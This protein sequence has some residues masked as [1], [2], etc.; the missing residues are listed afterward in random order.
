MQIINF[1]S[2]ENNCP[3]LKGKNSRTEYNFIINCSKELNQELISR[4]WR[5]FGS[6]FSRP[7]CKDCDDCVS[8]R[9][10]V[11]DFVF[12][13]QFKR[14]IKK[15]LNT[16]VVISKPKISD[17][18]IYIYNKYH[19]YMRKKRAW[20]ENKINFS[21]YYRLYVDGNGDFGYEL[22][23]Y[24]EQKL[25]CVDLID[26]LEDGISSIYC[27]YDPDYS[28]L[29]LGKFSLL[30]E[31]NIALKNELSYIYLGYFV[32]GCK[33]LA[34]KAD[35]SPNEILKGTTSLND[36]AKLWEFNN[37]NCSKLRIN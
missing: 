17:E 29:N 19:E 32:E 23:F 9:I 25:V 6:Y 24:V 8:Y 31:I 5:R 16:K 13:K 18:H 12:S 26:I 7:I 2:L 28:H 15:N 4:G 20:E 27:Y 36:S 37:A 3:Y 11:K 21:Q 14:V 33:S 10:L 35:Y 22:S 30:T 34:Y 1:C